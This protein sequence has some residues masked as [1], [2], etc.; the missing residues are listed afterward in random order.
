MG[1]GTNRRAVRSTEA[2]AGGQ[3]VGSSIGD[4]VGALGITVVCPGGAW[5]GV[6]CHVGELHMMTVFVI[7]FGQAQHVHRVSMRQRR[8]PFLTRRERR[9]EVGD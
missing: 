2:G 8:L 4:V 6:T 5:D 1:E 7:S 9:A 3:E